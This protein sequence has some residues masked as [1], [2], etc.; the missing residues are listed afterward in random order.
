MVA[1]G[2]RT[3]VEIVA[4]VAVSSWLWCRLFGRVVE[5]VRWSGGVCAIMEL[6]LSE[7]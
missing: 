6:G 4:I 2:G 7:W 3:K 5:V 1:W